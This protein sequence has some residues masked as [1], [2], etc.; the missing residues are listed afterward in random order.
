MAVTLQI[1]DVPADARDILA[2]QA[3]RQGR[4]L[5]SLLHELVTYAARTQVNADMFRATAEL[6][7]AVPP[8]L[9]ADV[10]VRQYRNDEDV[11]A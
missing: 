4:S 8:H 11:I 10:L 6:R 1:K 7:V 5:Q 9:R 3:E 2:D